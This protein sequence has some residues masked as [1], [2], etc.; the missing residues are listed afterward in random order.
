MSI[1][2][3]GLNN[4]QYF[5]IIDLIVLF[6]GLKLAT[7]KGDRMEYSIL[8]ITLRDDGT[9]CIVGSIRFEYCGEH[10]I[11]MAKDRGGGEAVLSCLNV[12]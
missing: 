8:R 11:E 12:A 3:H 10:R 1:S 4:C 7:V 2:A 5:L 6:R 9:K